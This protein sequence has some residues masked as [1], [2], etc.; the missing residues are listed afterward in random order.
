MK[1]RDKDSMIQPHLCRIDFESRT[2]TIPNR[3]LP[4]PNVPVHPTRDVDLRNI[5]GRLYLDVVIDPD[6]VSTPKYAMRRKS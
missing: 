2:N 5:Y 4:Q 1:R 6:P 3:L